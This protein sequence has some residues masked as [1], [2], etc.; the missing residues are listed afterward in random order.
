MAAKKARP[1]PAPVR[2]TRTATTSGVSRKN[3][4]PR[5]QPQPVTP[6]QPRR[7]KVVRPK[8]RKPSGQSWDGYQ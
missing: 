4:T 6:G 1:K 8:P 3:A 7:T 2:K 5:K